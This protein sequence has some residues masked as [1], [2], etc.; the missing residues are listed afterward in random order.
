MM[1]VV[2][3]RD[4]VYAA[5]SRYAQ[6]V[7]LRVF[8]Y[9]NNS[10]DDTNS[11]SSSSNSSSSDI[12]WQ[13]VASFEL[14]VMAWITLSVVAGDRVTCCSSS[15]RQVVLYSLPSGQPLT[16]HGTRG[17]G[18][19]AGQLDLPFVSDDDDSG[20]VLIADCHND[21]LQV[22]SEQ[23]EFSVLQLQPQVSRPRSALLF[24]EHLFVTSRDKHAI[25]KYA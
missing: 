19:G 17:S 10:S 11:S 21:R 4:R 8:T 14:S 20:S 23:G 7:V 6:P 22:M 24:D 15:E 13:Q 3:H 5:E 16:T 12:C 9:N 1:S 25:Y 2:V 18:G